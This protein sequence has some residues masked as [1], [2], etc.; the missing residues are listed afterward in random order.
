[1]G[2]CLETFLRFCRTFDKMVMKSIILI[3]ISALCVSE[4]LRPRGVPP[5][6]ANFYDPNSNFHCLD[7]SGEIPFEHVNDD[8]C[9]C[10][11]GSDE[12][13]TSACPT[14]KFYCAQR[15]FKPFLIP[16]SRVNDGI[17]DCCDGADEWAQVTGTPCQNN[18]D[19]LGA[20]DRVERERLEQLVQEGLRMKA[21]LAAKGLTARK[22]KEAKRLIKEEREKVETAALDVIRE[23]EERQKQAK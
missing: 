4:S 8:Y 6:M 17:C 9:D 3:V 23:E 21:E 18:C 5:D 22:E 13:G 2:Y 14:G 12:P 20:A 19:E 16:S 1:M 15:G 7:G 10:K 11:D